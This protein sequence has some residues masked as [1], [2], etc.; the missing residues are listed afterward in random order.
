ML[1]TS[2]ARRA[3]GKLPQRDPTT[4]ISWITIGARWRLDLSATV[5]FNTSVPRG[6]VALIAASRPA[7][8]PVASTTR[9]ACARSQSA[10]SRVCT[11]L[12]ARMASLSSCLPTASTRA[13]AWWSTCAISR[14]SL[15]SPSTVHRV[16]AVTCTCSR[17]SN[18]AASGSANTAAS[19]L[20]PGPTSCRFATGTA[21]RSAIA[22][23]AFRIPITVRVG[24]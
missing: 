8:V 3:G 22:P 10:R 5:L 23:S 20:T 16:A 18:A 17:I 19:S 4:L 12:F 7:A 6:R 14:P 1:L 21:M 11:P 9:S 2:S 15:P 24:Q 13:P